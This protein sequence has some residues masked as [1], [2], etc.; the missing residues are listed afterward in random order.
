MKELGKAQLDGNCM[1]ALHFHIYLVS[2]PFF[3]MSNPDVDMT[4]ADT[5]KNVSVHL[6]QC[7]EGGENLLNLQNELVTDSPR[8]FALATVLFLSFLGNKDT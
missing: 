6:L 7:I 5:A 1:W 3:G 2:P 4:Y 8:N